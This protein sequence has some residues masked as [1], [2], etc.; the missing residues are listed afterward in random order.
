MS[1]EINE[2]LQN[3]VFPMLSQKYGDF[4]FCEVKDGVVEIISLKKSFLSPGCCFEIVDTAERLL[5]E[6]IRGIEK[7][8]LINEWF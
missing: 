4:E 3:E 2:I 1:D 5:K 6:S 7:V 8:I